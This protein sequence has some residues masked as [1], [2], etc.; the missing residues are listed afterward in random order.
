MKEVIIPK[1]NTTFLVSRE[2]VNVSAT[3]YEPKLVS[4]TCLTEKVPVEI[5][6]N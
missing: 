3:L 2:G 5:L 4:R 1:V 6:K